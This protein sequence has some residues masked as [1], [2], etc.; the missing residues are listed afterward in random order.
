M[1]TSQ[2]SLHVFLVYQIFS[3]LP[4]MRRC[5]SYTYKE[6]NIFYFL[7]K[8][9]FDIQEKSFEKYQRA[10][11]PEKQKNA[12]LFEVKGSKDP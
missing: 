10:K 5:L 3:E 11:D 7:A 6:F 9:I 2:T 4:L 12:Q 1:K 8:F